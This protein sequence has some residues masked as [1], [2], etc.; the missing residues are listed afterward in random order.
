[1]LR[2]IREFGVG[3]RDSLIKVSDTDQGRSHSAL[4]IPAEQR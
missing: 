2:P 1:M 4:A 3:V